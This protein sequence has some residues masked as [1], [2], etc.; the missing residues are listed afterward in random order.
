[1]GAMTI[2]IPLADLKRKAPSKPPAFYHLCL[3]VGQVIDGNLH[4]DV[5]VYDALKGRSN[6][7]PEIPQPPKRASK[8]CEGQTQ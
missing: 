8:C 5:R 7:N 1:M 2:V 4:I 6:P 3:Q